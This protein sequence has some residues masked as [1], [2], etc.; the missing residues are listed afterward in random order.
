M[1]KKAYNCATG[2]MSE[3]NIYTDEERDEDFKDT[4]WKNKVYGSKV[5]VYGWHT[6]WDDNN[7]I[8]WVY[9]DSHSGFHE[10]EMAEFK[11]LH[12]RLGKAKFNKDILDGMKYIVETE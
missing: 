2:E 7:C 4:I 10:M 12:E 3:I 6:T 1:K 11:F 9:Y 5:R 8:Y